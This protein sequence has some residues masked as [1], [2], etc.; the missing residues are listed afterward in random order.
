[1]AFVHRASLGGLLY[2]LSGCSQIIGADEDRDL[3]KPPGEKPTWTAGEVLVPATAGTTAALFGIDLAVSGDT[4][5]I[6]APR[7]T[8][9]EGGYFVFAR[10]AD[11]WAQET[12]LVLTQIQVHG[13]QNGRSLA[14]SNGQVLIGLPSNVHAFERTPTWT[15]TTSIKMKGVSSFGSACAVNGDTL[16]VGAP[17]QDAAGQPGAGMVHVYVGSGAVYTEQLPAIEAPQATINGSFGNRVVLDGDTLAVAAE[18]STSGDPAVFVFT[19][20]NDVWTLQQEL[21]L[22]NSDADA[23][24][25]ALSLQGDTL[26]VGAPLDSEGGV[27]AGAVFVY[28]RQGTSWM[29]Q[30]LI[31]SDAES[32]DRFGES[33]S[34]DGDALLVGAPFA[35]SRGRNSGKAYL[36]RRT[37]DSWSETDIVITDATVEDAQFGF[38]VGLVGF[39][40]LVGAPTSG[41]GL[42]QVVRFDPLGS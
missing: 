20:A 34:I 7:L 23:F 21:A 16:A 8:P 33:V 39:E 17:L 4:A 15:N 27:S 40:G 41:G 28:A 24:G 3:R 13:G 38:A 18:R 12:Q 29:Q 26:A 30:K 36:F 14:V 19:R 5:V 1:M 25:D 11:A 35:G 31:P 2:L 6:S 37:G 9:S 42:V 32:G 22:P 10:G